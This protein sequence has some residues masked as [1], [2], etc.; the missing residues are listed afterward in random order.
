MYLES[1]EVIHVHHKSYVMTWLAPSNTCP[2]RTNV[3]CT[4]SYSNILQITFND[5]AWHFI[6]KNTIFEVSSHCLSW[7]SCLFGRVKKVFSIHHSLSL[8]VM[9]HSSVYVRTI[10]CATALGV[11]HAG[12]PIGFSTIGVPVGQGLPLKGQSTCGPPQSCLNW[13]KYEKLVNVMHM[14]YIYI[15]YMYRCTWRDACSTLYNSI[16]VFMCTCSLLEQRF[17]E[18]ACFAGCKPGTDRRGYQCQVDQW[19][20][21]PTGVT[22][23]SKQWWSWG[24]TGVL[25]RIPDW[26]M[27]SKC[28]LGWSDPLIPV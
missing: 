26:P 14:Y 7:W 3:A 11:T 15:M 24:P 10:I 22:V 25:K 2:L 19:I 16:F 1:D 18:H 12:L 6:G 4:C 21:P 23:F 9:K 13:T 27:N 28:F 20:P 5:S 17:S 8:F